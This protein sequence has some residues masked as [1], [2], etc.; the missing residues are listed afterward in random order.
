MN[1]GQA[2][3]ELVSSEGGYSNDPQ[4][5]GNWTSGII[6]KGQLKGTKYGI[7]ANTY[8]DMDI[9][10]LTLEQAKD[11]Y[12]RDYWDIWQLDG[13]SHQVPDALVFE[14]FD[15]AVNAGV[16]NARRFLQRAVGVADDGLIGSATISAL[17]R[18]LEANGI[19]RVEMWFLAEKLEHY[20]RL[21]SFDRFGRGWA[22]RVVKS[23]RNI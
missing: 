19:A 20:T 14:L 11:I 22:R 8:G 5:P 6:G 4:D 2:F 10:N 1:F 3:A 17:D 12:K 9:A 7:A 21:K 16:G 15:A 23:M 13:L 18:A